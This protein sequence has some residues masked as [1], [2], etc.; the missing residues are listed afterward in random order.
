MNQRPLGNTGIRCSELGLGTWGLSGDGYGPVAEPEVDR[1]LLRARAMNVNLFET[2]DVYGNGQME[3]RLGHHFGNDSSVCIVTK[4]GTCL[5]TTPP[6]KRFDVAWLEERLSQSA[7]RLRRQCIDVVLLHNPSVRCLE[8]GTAVRWLQEQQAKG[9]VRSWGVSAGSDQVARAALDSGAPVLELAVNLLWSAA[10]RE[11]APRLTVSQTGILARSIL[12]HGLLC[13]YWSSDKTF[14]PEDHRS[15]R[16]SSEDLQRRLRQVD[17]LRSLVGDDVPSL[18]AL[19]LRWVLEQTLISSA[20]LGPRSTLQL[21][22]LLRD[23][24]SGP[25]YVDGDTLA[26]VESRLTQMRV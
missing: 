7:E 1:V 16:W 10:L 6:R 25:P 18:R 2:A 13:G 9:T 20:V 19:A 12:A 21:D 22:Q 3:A 17:G 4:L 26:A 15:E 23:A 11:L 14:A 24:G 5:D 8:E